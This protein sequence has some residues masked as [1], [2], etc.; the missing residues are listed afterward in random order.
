MTTAP[1]PDGHR[2]GRVALVVALLMLGALLG[3]VVGVAW[4]VQSHID[5]AVERIDDPLAGV[6]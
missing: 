4:L 2:S 1:P 3:G 5:S 6:E